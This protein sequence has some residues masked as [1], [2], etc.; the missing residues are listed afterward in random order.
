MISVKHRSP[1]KS[2]EASQNKENR[3]KKRSSNACQRC[4]RQKIKCSGSQ[5]CDT[6][7]KRKSTCTF[8]DRDQKILV[9]RGYLEDLQ[10]QLALLKGGEDEAFSPQS[11]EQEVL[12]P[13]TEGKASISE[14]TGRAIP[15]DP[16][17]GGDDL[18][19]EGEPEWGHN[20]EGASQLTNPLS[21][22]PS[23][24]MAAAS[25]RIFY[26]GTSSNWS[27][28]RKILSMTHE[29]LYNAPLP[30][31]SLYFDGSAYDL[32]WEGTRTTVTHEIP[33]APPLDFSIYLINAVKFHAGQLFHLFDEE[34]FMDGLYAFYE[35]PEHQMAHSG[36]WY[37]H[38]LL[39]LAFGKA[40]V[41]QRNQGSR[42]SG[43]EFFTKALQ[44]LPDTT[45]LCRDPIVATEILCCIALYL[46][47]LD[48]RNS[49]HNY[50]GQA[51]RIAQAQGMHTNMSA[52][53]LGD[54]I[55][56]RCRR[57]WWTIYILDRQM[58]SLMGLPQSIRDD[59]LHHQ[60]P[61]FPGSPQKAI[62]LSMQ[63]KVCQI[64]DEISSSVYGP[65]GRL[66]RNFLL[67][68]KSALASAAEVITE[69]RKC[70]DL[71]LDESSI[72]G[73][74]RLSAHLHLLYHQCIVLATRPVLFC[75]LKMRIQ[76]TDSSLESLNSSANVR[77]LLQVCIDSAQQILNILMVLQRQNLLDS[78]LP[79][80]LEATYTAAVVLVTAPAAD[81]SL[82]DDW[83]PWFHTSV[84]VLDEM[85]S[86]GNLIAGFRKSELQQLAGMLSQL[87]TDGDLH[88]AE[89]AR[90]GQLDRIISRLP[91]PST[92]D[93]VF[94]ISEI[95]NLNPGLTTDEIMAVAE[96]IDTGDVDWIAHAVTENHIW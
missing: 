30:T 3:V 15:T 63:I 6:C 43:C 85:I 25:G 4:R 55:V 5:P 72:S 31:G 35:N 53:H 36:L 42:P 21:S 24:F 41:V 66:N 93:R 28:A 94:G 96:S 19:V 80:D 89:L 77:K 78:F 73:V 39:I 88:S 20:L 95:T 71:R 62:A 61:Y 18:A 45:N 1:S 12:R 27:F 76:T 49:A 34:T 67:R 33:M 23:T 56:Q 29:H 74:S 75:F 7:S 2:M 50:I 11:M 22:G 64:M 38:Y 26:L 84:T 9:T 32:G 59:Q 44:L 46:Q 16:M 10:R 17:L 51:A 79:F 86:R 52:E 54:A 37:I 58:T 70:Y 47:S 60:L 57:I 13:T 83:T 68:T 87:T 91:S 14:A 92:P 82:L 81:A 69:L 48:C 90:K 65:D 8:D 40:F